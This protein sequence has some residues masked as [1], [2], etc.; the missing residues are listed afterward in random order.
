VGVGFTGAKDYAERTNGATGAQMVHGQ[1]HLLAGLALAACSCNQE[2]PLALLTV[3][4]DA[5]QFGGPIPADYTCDG[6]GDSPPLSWSGAPKSTA[7]FALIVDDPDAP[8]PDA[9]TKTVVHW[10]VYDLAMEQRSL[11]QGLHEPPAGARQGS[12]STGK[13]GYFPP[14]PGRGR[15]RYFF[16]LYALDAQLGDLEVPTKDELVDAMAHHVIAYGEL[17]GRYERPKH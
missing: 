5:F 15:H 2:R 12:N 4:S 16:K 11:A 3:E 1:T 10:V 13:V 8:S 9:P 14:C 17:M 6:A 7:S